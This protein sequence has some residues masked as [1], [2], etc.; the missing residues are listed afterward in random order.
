MK[1][2]NPSLFDR[3][4]PQAAIDHLYAIARDSYSSSG[5]DLPIYTFRAEGDRLLAK[6]ELSIGPLRKTAQLS[7][8]L[9]NDVSLIEIQGIFFL[10]SEEIMLSET[11]P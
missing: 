7:I 8:E 10:L 9:A 1:E 5:G 2:T 6:A 3:V 11:N 4:S